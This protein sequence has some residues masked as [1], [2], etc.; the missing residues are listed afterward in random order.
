MTKEPKIPDGL[1]HLTGQ[2][3][4]LPPILPL[5]L[6]SGCLLL[7]AISMLS[8]PVSADTFPYL[9]HGVVEGD[10]SQPS[11][12]QISQALTQVLVRLTGIA[13]PQEHPQLT[14]LIE[15]S[16]QLV[17]EYELLQ[18]GAAGK[19][20]FRIGFHR[21]ELTTHLKAGNLS[22][23]DSNHPRLLLFVVQT[24]GAHPT[25]VL[26][27]GDDNAQ[28][29]GLRVAIEH[30]QYQRGLIMMLPIQ[31][32][33]EQ[34]LALR[35]VLEGHYREAASWLKKRYGVDAVVLILLEQIGA[36]DWYAESRF[37]GDVEG[38][39]PTGQSHDIRQILASALGKLG[40]F[41][42]ARNAR[43]PKL[44]RGLQLAVE[45]VNTY[46]DFQRLLRILDEALPIEQRP[47]LVRMTARQLE[48]NFR[49]EFPV[50][51]IRQLL[52]G[53]EGITLIERNFV[54][55]D[56]IQIHARLLPEPVT[57][58]DLSEL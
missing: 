24:D 27:H 38:K 9:Y 30:L 53:Q 32:Y 41:Y 57:P 6:R 58:P 45:N 54:P 19:P 2:I 10:G 42:W 36:K 25:H 56:R 1:S 15:S 34:K 47:S 18:P 3:T 17:S 37:L 8:A 13:K 11:P 44:A 29:V 28:S 51:R 14:E 7:L 21:H 20:R 39:L 40:D 46:T 22:V 43:K 50:T 48:F 26:H 31:D 33:A 16:T 12:A 4:L 5:P 52:S 55:G 49:S 23:W 35:Q